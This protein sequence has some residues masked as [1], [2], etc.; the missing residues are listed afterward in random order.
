MGRL[1]EAAG[2]RAKKITMGSYSGRARILMTRSIMI[3]LTWI[4]WEISLPPITLLI[5]S[6]LAVPL[7]PIHQHEPACIET[8]LQRRKEIHEHIGNPPNRTRLSYHT[9]EFHLQGQIYPQDTTK[10]MKPLQPSRERSR[11]GG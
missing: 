1:V 7:V 2:D 11:Q 10:K 3:S 4:P 6:P 5:V 9:T 8:R